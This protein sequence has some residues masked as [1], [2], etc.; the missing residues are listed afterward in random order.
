VRGAI[1][2]VWVVALM[3]NISRFFDSFIKL[4]GLIEWED[5][6]SGFY[7]ALYNN[8]YY[9]IFYKITFRSI[10][11]TF[12]PFSLLTFFTVR[13][14]ASLR[15]SFL[16]QSTLSSDVSK[17]AEKVSAK[18][19]RTTSTLVLI[20]VI[21]LLFDVPLISLFALQLARR[22]YQTVHR[23]WVLFPLNMTSI[24]SVMIQDVAY[25]CLLIKST[26]NFFIFCVTGKRYR[27]IFRETCNCST[28]Q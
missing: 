14:L 12:L 9:T 7:F 2:V 5:W 17:K 26:M 4:D 21:F 19:R 20:V 1:V 3:L 11:T 13:V 27:Q 8:P 28:R 15:E 10:I 22:F 24:A 25:F 6:Y 18:Q 23:E 16:E